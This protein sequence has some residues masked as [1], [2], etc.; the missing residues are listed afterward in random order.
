ML[1]GAGVSLRLGGLARVRL[2]APMSE[3]DSPVWAGV[4]YLAL[5]VQRSHTIS[6][7]F[8]SHTKA[9][10]KFSAITTNLTRV[11]M[12]TSKNENLL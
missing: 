3:R 2:E 5:V 10:P 6:N 11:Q 4:G 1:A 7:V 9:I 8:L 12:Y